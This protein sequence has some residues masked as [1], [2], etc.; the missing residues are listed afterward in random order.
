MVNELHSLFLHQGITTVVRKDLATKENR[1]EA[2]KQLGGLE[3]EEA[4]WI[5][6]TL[7]LH[8][9]HIAALDLEMAEERKGDEDIERLMTVPGVGPIVS[10]AFVAF[11]GDGIR[12]DNASQVSNYLGL[13]PKVDISG[14]TVRIGEITKRGNGYLRALLVQAAWALV[15][16]KSG[17]ALKERYR[18]MTQTKG[19]GK[20]KSIIAVARRLAELL[21]TLLRQGT[22]YEIRQFAAA[23]Q[24]TAAKNLVNEAL[25]G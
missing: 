21:W 11:I 23:A 22:T 8:D 18:Y 13:T 1:E 7:E 4:Q 9:A 25:A 20:K 16:A 2:V 15:R 24:E 6:Q 17:G 3:R 12:F 5:L 19:L 10:L 14:D